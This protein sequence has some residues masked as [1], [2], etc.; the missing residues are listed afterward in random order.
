MSESNEH[1]RVA[2]LFPGQG[3]QFPGMADPWLDHPAGKE[4]LEQASTVLGW[5]VAAR[6]QDPEALGMTEVVQPALFAVDL[7]AFAV[8]RAEGVP[9]D[10]AAGHSLGEYAA[11]VASGAVGFD[12]GL[13]ALAT[14]AEAM[15]RASRDNPGAMTALIGL[16]PAEAAGVCEVAGRG[17]VLAVANENGPKQIVLS[18]SV[19][20]VERAE[21]L[22]RTRGGK[23]VRLQVAGAFHSPLMQPALQP[24]RDALARIEFHEPAFDLVP[25]VSAKP[26]R[27]PLVLRDLL[28]RHL[29]SP[30]RWEASMRAMGRS[31]VGWFLE[32]GPG[33]VLGKLARR[34]VPEAQVRQIGTPD[35]AVVVA[36][37]LRRARGEGYR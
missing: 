30:V 12:E 14:R 29:V 18:G 7:A 17:D 10:A 3:S 25:N 34:A 28:A 11:L 23:A 35:A 31:G 13:A 24:V 19:A 33:D 21:E 6:T 4:V 1:R 9:C 36:A 2:V 27:N 5:D 15:G 32:A 22:A 8:L 16:S 37:E 20:A 26:T